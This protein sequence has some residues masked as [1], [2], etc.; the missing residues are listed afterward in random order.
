MGTPLGRGQAINCGVEAGEVIFEY[1]DDPPLLVSGGQ[2][3]A[4]LSDALQSDVRNLRSHFAGTHVIYK[5]LRF[6]QVVQ[7]A[8]LDVVRS[9]S[10]HSLN[11]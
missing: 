6:E 8:R 7:V 9:D 2:G 10:C 1:V 11:E 5:R 3:D 4:E